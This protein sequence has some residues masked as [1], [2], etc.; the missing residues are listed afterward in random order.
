MPTFT[1]CKQF[2][3]AHLVDIFYLLL[4]FIFIPLRP[5]AVFAL[6]LTQ[7]TPENTHTHTHTH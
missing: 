4:S 5:F 2:A 3:V 1:C 6:A 7:L